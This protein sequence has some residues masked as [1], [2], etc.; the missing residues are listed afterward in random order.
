L[1]DDPRMLPTTEEGGLSE[2]D[3]TY[4]C[5]PDL[6]WYCPALVLEEPGHPPPVGRAEGD[7]AAS[8]RTKVK[9]HQL[10]GRGLEDCEVVAHPHVH[11]KVVGTGR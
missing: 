1:D 11:E 9:L 8:P 5:F 6:C 7:I 10:A 2:Q 3:W 4:L